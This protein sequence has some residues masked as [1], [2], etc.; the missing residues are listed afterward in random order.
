MS[1]Q[2][3]L[4][5]LKSTKNPLP[6]IGRKDKHQETSLVKNPLVK[7]DDPQDPEKHKKM[8]KE[9]LTTAAKSHAKKPTLKDLSLAY[10]SSFFN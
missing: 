8:S 1:Q 3:P 4:P 10:R 2:E 5:H 7:L 9:E 6:G